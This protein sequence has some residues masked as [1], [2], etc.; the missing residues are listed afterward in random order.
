VASIGDQRLIDALTSDGA[1]EAFGEGVGAWGTDWGADDP[2][3]S[4][5][6]TSSK[7]GVNLVSRSRISNFTGRARSLSS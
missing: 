5:R 1:D 6:K 3:P 7:A 4:V 2:D